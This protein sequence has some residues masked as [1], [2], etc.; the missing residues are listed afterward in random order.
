MDTAKRR[1]PLYLLGISTLFSISILDEA[2]LAAWEALRM[3][4]ALTRDSIS[5]IGMPEI[6]GDHDP[7]QCLPETVK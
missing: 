6:H 7:E 2:M 3:G 4:C 5:W 1:G